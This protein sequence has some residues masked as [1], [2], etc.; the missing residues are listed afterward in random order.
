[1]ALEAKPLGGAGVEFTAALIPGLMVVT[2][3]LQKLVKHSQVLMTAIEHSIWQLKRTRKCFVPTPEESIETASGLAE[4]LA[5]LEMTSSYS[6][7]SERGQDVVQHP[8]PS[9]LIVKSARPAV[10]HHGS[11]GLVGKTP[12]SFLWESVPD[13]AAGA[14]RLR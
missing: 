8:G 5:C 13:C 12:W 14:G 6:V 9:E 10:D 2:A 3:T 7:S 1:V 11:A 4:L